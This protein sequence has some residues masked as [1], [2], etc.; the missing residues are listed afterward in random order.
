MKKRLLL[1]LCLPLIFSCSENHK[2]EEK[3]EMSKENI[4]DIIKD[5]YSD[6]I[7]LNKDVNVVYLEEFSVCEVPESSYLID[8]YFN[9]DDTLRN[10]K[11]FICEED[12]Y[13]KARYNWIT[14]TSI[15]ITLYESKGDSSVSLVAR[16][17]MDGSGSGIEFLE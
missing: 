11:I 14:D 8:M 5:D 6:S 2:E 7:H 10:A 12:I 1:L 16:G 9:G 3:I 17:M 15:N 13:D 4:I